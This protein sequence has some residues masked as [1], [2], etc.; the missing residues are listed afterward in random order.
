MSEVVLYNPS[1]KQAE[2]HAFQPGDLVQILY[3][4]SAGCGKTVLLRMDPFVT[5]IIPEYHRWKEARNRGDKFESQGWALHLR[6]NSPMLKQ[7]VMKVKRIAEQFDPGCEWR[8]RDQMIIFSFGYIYQFGHCSDEDSWRSYDTNEYTWLGL[9]EATQ[10]TD[11]QRRG[12]S[13]RVRTSDP[14]LNKRRRIIFASNPDSPACGLWVK[15]EFV[16]PCP[17]GGKML[18]SKIEMDDGTEENVYKIFFPAFL[19]DNPDKVFAR[20]YEAT[21]R[22]TLASHLLEA[23]LKCNWNVVEGAFFE[24]EFIP[25]IHV[26][27]PFPIEDHWIKARS[28]DYGFKSPSVVIRAAK[29]EDQNVIIFRETNFNYKL[30]SESQRADAELQAMLIKKEEKEHGE[31]DE[32]KECSKYSGPADNSINRD[33]GNGGSTVAQRMA[34]KGVYWEQ[35]IKN[36]FAGTQELLRLL[37]DRPKGKRPG[38]IIFKTCKELIEC[39]QSIKVSD[40]DPELPEDG[41]HVNDHWLDS[42]FYLIQYIANRHTPKKTHREEM[43]LDE[44]GFPIGDVVA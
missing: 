41:P 24:N 14:I 29:D 25:K 22:A 2:V 11:A 33:D 6:R 42:L 12:I 31:W 19:Y 44:D 26:C 27:D 20:N 10:F 1:P 32:G 7:T 28:L 35:C 40:K 5:Q 17:E 4:G 21:M 34:E 18:V 38:I 43:M 16:D 36:R 9:D 8:E 39:I 30:K 3:G 15:N 13:S 37:K 23:R